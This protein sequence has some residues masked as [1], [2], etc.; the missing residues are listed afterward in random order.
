MRNLYFKDV[1][2]SSNKD[3]LLDLTQIETT[4]E[5]TPQI[6]LLPHANLSSV[7]PLFKKAFSFKEKFNN[8]V[9]LSPLH[10]EKLEGDDDN[11]LFTCDNDDAMTPLGSLD[12]EPFPCA[13][14]KENYFEEE[15][16]IEIM[17]PFLARYLNNS[18]IL[19]VFCDITKKE[20]IV[21]LSK[22]IKEF[23][24]N[25]N[26]TL[27]I[28]SGNLTKQGDRAKIYKEAEN[29]IR[30][31]E[32]NESLLSPFQSGEITCCASLIIEAFRQA[33]PSPW[34]V[35]MT[36]C[37]NYSGKV[38]D[39]SGDGRNWMAFAHKDIIWSKDKTLLTSPFK[40]RKRQL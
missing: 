8:V 40:E 34:E 30:L 3:E 38:I 7:A 22:Y 17:L 24:K 33:F 18:K 10:K 32:D 20:E 16:G 5:T 15:Y 31:L 28:I 29:V 19:P 6:L 25:D 13:K 26:S 37:G 14:I 39:T 12:F 23:Y 9:I 21:K 2:Y 35:V 11:F 36:K 27:F 1:F 4:N